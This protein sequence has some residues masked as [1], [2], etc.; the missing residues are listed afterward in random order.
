MS[1]AEKLSLSGW[2]AESVVTSPRTSACQAESQVRVD[3]AG[4]HREPGLL[5]CHGLE[6]EHPALAHVHQGRTAPQ[7]QR[8]AKQ[9]GGYPR[10]PVLG[11]RPA[12]QSQ[13]AELLEVDVTCSRVEQVAVLPGAEHALGVM[14][15]T[16]GLRDLPSDVNNVGL[17]GRKGAWRRVVSPELLDE[18]RNDDHPVRL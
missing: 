4:D 9:L 7:D 15:G 6:L 13:P 8:P 14:A 2:R 16:H 11:R 17:Q 10:I 12:G 3:A 1:C 5:E 18:R